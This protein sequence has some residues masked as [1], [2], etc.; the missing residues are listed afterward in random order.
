MYIF[1]YFSFWTL[2]YLFAL[3]LVYIGNMNCFIYYFKLVSHVQ[4]LKLLCWGRFWY[5][6]YW[7]LLDKF[8][9][10]VRM[11][12]S[13]S[14]WYSWHHTSVEGKSSELKG[15]YKK[16]KERMTIFT[17]ISLD[18]LASRCC[19]DS[20]HGGEKMTPDVW[21]QI[22]RWLR[23]PLLKQCYLEFKL[24]HSLVLNSGCT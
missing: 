3:F 6:F 2:K 17:I 18:F 16:E 4:M 19:G 5:N 14:S 12:L 20:W 22:V 23:M 11:D 13:K 15:T 9:L 8:S 10:W 7:S 1:N 21:K 24:Y